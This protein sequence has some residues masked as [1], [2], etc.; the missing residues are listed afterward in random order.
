MHHINRVYRT[1]FPTVS[2]QSCPEGAKRDSC[3]LT[4][5][6]VQPYPCWLLRRA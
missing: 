1:I 2:R 6:D 4:I 3:C 5:F